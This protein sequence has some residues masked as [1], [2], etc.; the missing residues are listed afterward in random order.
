M[1]PFVPLTLKQYGNSTSEAFS[2]FGIFEAIVIPALFFR[3]V[4]FAVCP[5]F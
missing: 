3:P 2:Q 4:Y 1:T 5:V